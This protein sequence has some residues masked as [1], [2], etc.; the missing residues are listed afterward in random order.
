MAESFQDRLLCEAV[1]LDTKRAGLLLFLSSE[2]FTGLDAA[3]QFR[4]RIQY[5]IMT[6]YSEILHQRIAALT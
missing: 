1:E 4:M 6:L 2:V 3:E 5:S